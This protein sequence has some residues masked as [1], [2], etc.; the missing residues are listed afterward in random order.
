MPILLAR[1]DDRLI[2]GQV[3]IGWGRPLGLQRIILVDDDVAAS[4]WEQE[5]YRSAVPESIDVVFAGV[6]AAADSLEVWQASPLRTG[7]LTGN[8]ETMVQLHASAPQVLAQVNLG[9]IHHQPG[10]SERLPYLYL[11][12]TELDALRA[13]AAAGA[14]VTAQDVPTAAPVPLSAIK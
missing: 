2:H 4:G 9:G 3:V 11:T 7:L 12:G 13:L 6:A 5:L 1:V 14:K 8:L 10:R